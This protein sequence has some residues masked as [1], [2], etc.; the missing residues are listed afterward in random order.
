MNHVNN[1]LDYVGD[2]ED[3]DDDLAQLDE[4]EELKINSNYHNR[5]N[6]KSNNNYH[7]ISHDKFNIATTSPYGAGAWNAGTINQ[8]KS[9]FSNNNNM[10]AGNLGNYQYGM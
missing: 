6:N 2:E 8:N 5:S 7:N 10:A 1:N 4:D 3:E 9:S